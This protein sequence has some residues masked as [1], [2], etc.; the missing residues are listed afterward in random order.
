MPACFPVTRCLQSHIRLQYEFELFFGDARPVVPEVDVQPLPAFGVSLVMDLNVGAIPIAQ[1]VVHDI[2]KGAPQTVPALKHGG[3]VPVQRY[4]LP[5]ALP[6]LHQSFQQ[7]HHR[8]RPPDVF[9]APRAPQK[10]NRTVQR[11]G[12]IV[13]VGAQLFPQIVLCHLFEPQP[14]PGQRGAQVVRKRRQEA[15]PFLE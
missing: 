11:I 13:H 15:F 10:R 8:N 3:R 4:P 6:V 7:R 2:F 9:N 1:R 5:N 14:Q 12:Q